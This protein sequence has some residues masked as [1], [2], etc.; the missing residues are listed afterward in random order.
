MVCMYHE[1]QKWS[2]NTKDNYT[3]LK[4]DIKNILLKKQR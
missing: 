3:E 4:N 2:L 1:T